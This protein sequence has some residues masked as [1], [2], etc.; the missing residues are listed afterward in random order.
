VQSLG[1][2]CPQCGKGHL[3]EKRSKKGKTFYSCD[4]YP[5]CDFSVWERP[6]PMP[7]PKCGGLMTVMGRTQRP[8]GPQKVKCTRCGTIAEY[9]GSAP[10]DTETRYVAKGA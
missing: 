2:E 10:E 4:R 6:V 1:V 5:D 8:D 9:S 7:C 3:V